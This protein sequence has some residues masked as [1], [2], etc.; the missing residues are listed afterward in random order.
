MPADTVVPSH[1][2]NFSSWFILLFGR[3]ATV[4]C[5]DKTITWRIGR[6]HKV[7]SGAVH[8]LYTPRSLLFVSFQHHVEQIVSAS[9]DF[10]LV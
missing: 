8:W 4:H 10:Q 6:V 9:E 3:G 2:H 7:P 5:A 1:T